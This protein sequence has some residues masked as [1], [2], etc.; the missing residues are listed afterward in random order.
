MTRRVRQLILASIAIVMMGMSLPVGAAS[1][2]T[3]PPFTQLP[4]WCQLV[5]ARTGCSPSTTGEIETSLA[6]SVLPV[7]LR[8]FNLELYGG[9]GP[10][11]LEDNGQTNCRGYEPVIIK[12]TWVPC[13]YGLR[14]SRRVIVVTG[15][16]EAE[17][18]VPA[19]DVW[20]QQNGFRIVMLTFEGCPPWYYNLPASNKYSYW[21]ACLVTW[22]HKVA[23][24]LA[25]THPV[26]VVASGMRDVA[27]GT[28]PATTSTPAL[29][30]A[31]RSFFTEA[32]PAGTI[33]I[34]LTNYPWFFSSP[35]L[36]MTCASVH[37]T[38]LSQ[39]NGTI[40]SNVDAAYRSAF[41]QIRNLH[42][43]H[44]VVVDTLPLFCN[45]TTSQCPTVGSNAF[46]YIDS[47]HLSTVWSWHVGRA[48]STLLA[49]ILS[50]PAS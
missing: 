7:A 4:T 38:S 43:P 35:Q 2:A 9:S 27:Q 32:V 29:V 5:V 22:R 36:P 16:S 45:I 3:M 40:T 49:P 12:S 19:F 47:H 10:T 1:P 50:T 30:T 41:L 15:D 8:T 42:L 17:S 44:T 6:Q 20:G 37:A 39:C 33:G 26:A 11:P 21:S 46:L 31:M 18:W 25:S 48:L 28:S 13:S 34:A 24:Y 14:S 23:T